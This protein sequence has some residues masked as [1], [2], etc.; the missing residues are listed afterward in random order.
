MTTKEREIGKAAYEAF[1]RS[2]DGTEY[3]GLNGQRGWA[4]LPLIVQ[5][6]WMTAAA[7]VTRRVKAD[8]PARDTESIAGVTP[9]NSATQTLP[10]ES[11]LVFGELAMVRRRLLFRLWD[12]KIQTNM[13][14][15]VTYLAW[16]HTLNDAIK[17]VLDDV[18]FVAL[19]DKTNRYAA[20]VIHARPIP[21]P[22][23]DTEDYAE[24]VWVHGVRATE[25][26][27]NEQ[28]E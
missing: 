17:A 5:T 9:V 21:R 24:V 25:E 12:V 10:D 13:G 6:A 14:K 23:T 15:N 1:G 3:L 4:E 27:R 18:A 8:E 11:D 28:A 16:A 19:G 20:E 26:Q 22:D 2:M 7:E